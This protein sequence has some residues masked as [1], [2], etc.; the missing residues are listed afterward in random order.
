MCWLQLKL[1]KSVVV[2][3]TRKV[4]HM[5]QIAA[6]LINLKQKRNISLNKIVLLTM[7]V[8]A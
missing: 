5:C 6:L 1:L 7:M 4:E 8:V 3:L 2:S